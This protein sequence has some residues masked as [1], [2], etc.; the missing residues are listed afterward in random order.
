MGGVDK[1]RYWLVARDKPGL[2]RAMMRELVGGARISFEGDLARCEFG[3]QLGPSTEETP[4]LLRHTSYPRQ[5]FVVLPL[6]PQTVQPILDIVLPDRR[7]MTDIIHIQIE[8]T[9]RLEFG[10]YDNFHPDCIVCFHGVSPELLNRL[11]ANG[12]I[13][14]WTEPYEGAQ[15][16]HG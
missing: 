10:S 14:S 15:R 16:W 3:E 2:L 5:D 7:Y 4:A 13:K 12:V 6:E 11:Q 9:G 8:K 1:D